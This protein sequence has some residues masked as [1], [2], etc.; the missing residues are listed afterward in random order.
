MTRLMW[1]WWQL[2][3]GRGPPNDTPGGVGFRTFCHDCSDRGHDLDLSA[4]YSGPCRQLLVLRCT[5]SASGRQTW[6][7]CE[8]RSRRP[9]PFCCNRSD[10]MPDFTS[11]E[12]LAVALSA[13]L[14]APREQ[15]PVRLPCARPKPNQRGFPDRLTLT[16]A[17][18]S[19]ATSKL[20]A[21][22]WCWRTAVPIRA[23][24]SASCP[25]ACWIWSG[26]TGTR[27]II[28]VTTSPAIWTSAMPT[29]PPARCCRRAPLCCGSV[30]SR[31]WLR[32]MEGPHGST[33]L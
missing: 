19:W 12:A 18:G 17:V 21:L 15:G 26:A 23:I 8:T 27:A 9:A 6:R 13:V 7:C 20:R 33:R 10:R 1:A 29:C 25:R 30:T 32:Q 11:A 31:R 28:P 3:T 24:R 16:R 22:G 14:G 4:S 5:P 2:R